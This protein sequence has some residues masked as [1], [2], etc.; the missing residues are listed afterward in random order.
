MYGPENPRAKQPVSEF[1]MPMA[2]HQLKKFEQLN[3]VRVNVFRPSN[4]KLIPFR[5]SN[6]QNFEFNLD[7]F[8]LS[9]GSMHHYVLIRN[10]K[11]LVHQYI[12]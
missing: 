8:L 6:N 10:I 3:Q 9:D 5:I 2:F 12:Q 11:G 4:T 7:L 1:M